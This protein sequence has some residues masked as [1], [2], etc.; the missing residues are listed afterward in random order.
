MLK[1]EMEN[2]DLIRLEECIFG[3]GRRH[4]RGGVIASSLRLLDGT[5]VWF[6]IVEILQRSSAKPEQNGQNF[7][8]QLSNASA[9]KRSF[10][11]WWTCSRN[12]TAFPLFLI[13]SLLQR[14]H[15]ILSSK[16]KKKIFLAIF[17]DVSINFQCLKILV[18]CQF[19][20][21]HFRKPCYY[22]TRFRFP[23]ISRTWWNS[24]ISILNWPTPPL[25]VCWRKY[26]WW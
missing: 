7:L 26:M 15:A 20:D 25:G 4:G 12:I 5:P 18:S 11:E 16:I 8:I 13:N 24:I 6:D 9:T 10:L 1:R 2:I 22:S 23:N 3:F 19:I 17:I 14:S 21:F